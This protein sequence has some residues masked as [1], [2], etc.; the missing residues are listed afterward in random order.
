[1]STGMQTKSQAQKNGEVSGPKGA[2]RRQAAT[3]VA[4]PLSRALGNQ[5]FGRLLSRP[6]GSTGGVIQR[7]CA[8][9]G[10]CSKCSG[11]GE[12][13]VQTKLRVSQ[14]GD[15][16]EQEADHTADTVM[17]MPAGR[18]NPIPAAGPMLVQRAESMTEAEE[19]K[20]GVLIDAEFGIQMKGAGGAG[21]TAGSFS[22]PSSGGAPLA[23]PVRSFFEGR[24]G[25][26][27]SA[28]RVHTGT[29]A[30]Q[31]AQA[32]HARAY[33]H[34]NHIVFR[35]GEYSP[36]SPD[37][38]WLL[39]H[40]LTHVAQQGY[41]PAHSENT[42]AASRM[43]PSAVQRFGD[44]LL[45]LSRSIDQDYAKG[46]TDVELEAAI[47]HL[48]DV[49]SAI[50]PPLAFT[51]ENEAQQAN[52][53]LLTAERERRKP[54]DVPFEESE[55]D[56]EDTDGPAAPVGAIVRGDPANLRA[57]PSETG[58]PIPLPMNTKLIIESEQGTWDK[59]KT[60]D[61]RSGWIKK[62]LV[63]TNLPDPDS[64]L[65]IIQGS[66]TAQKIA[67]HFYG[68]YAK[69][70]GQD[71]RF[72]VNVLYYIN[73]QFPAQPGSRNIYR[74]DDAKEDWDKTVV[75]KGTKIWIPGVDAAIALKGVVPS[76]S[77]TH[78][79]WDT[80][81]DVF[82]G[83]TAFIV[84]LLEGALESIIDV[85]VGLWDLIK[86]AWSVVKSLI[87]GEILSD[88]KKLIDDISKLKLQDI[89]DAGVAWFKSKWFAEGTW[90]RWKFRGWLI[91]YVI[92]EILML[93][94]SDGIATALKWVGKT[95]KLAKVLE[96][97][98]TIVKLA[99][100]AKK[101]TGPAVDGVRAAAK[102]L[103]AIHAW[104]MSVLRIPLEIIK[105]TAEA[106]L[107]PLKGLPEWIKKKFGDLAPAFMKKLLGCASPCKVNVHEIEEWFKKLAPEAVK[108]AKKLE[109]IE[110]I[111]AALP[112]RM[113]T[114]LIKKKLKTRP[115]L[116]RLIKEAKL[117][118]VDL[119]KL[120]AFLGEGENAAS[121]YRTFVKY[122][123]NVVP[124]KT[125]GNLKKLN[126]IAEALVEADARQ[127]AALKGP[128]FENF[129]KINV[130]ELG[131]KEFAKV[132]FK[133]SASLKLTK[134]TRTADNFVESTGAVWDLKHGLSKVPLDQVE[135]Y[136][137][138]IGQLTPNGKE[139][140]T[141][142]YLFA[143]E[144]MAKENAQLAAKAGFNVHYLDPATNAIVKLKL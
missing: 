124:V 35:N 84:G 38:G 36:I 2:V 144:A 85:F 89:V 48:E 3:A 137:K 86:I 100:K 79:A 8:C 142:N 6:A 39:A 32:L 57:A 98:P 77:I 139:V 107:A 101:L 103:S 83:S 13:K 12:E 115:A 70:W 29:A 26:D 60:E 130:P 62:T 34:R 122:L 23:G 78:D 20:Q 61:G 49:L 82:I 72:F 125:E 46:L 127:G 53:D 58:T 30:D 21:K 33:T 132:T 126:T 50:K 91:G 1:M 22:V 28:V 120:E 18:I 88:I 15:R 87:T 51:P 5:A 94:F 74:P 31:S 121:A 14:P 123:T 41:A 55:L 64:T 7:K 54:D 69:D 68:A 24:M 141:I 96:K 4:M 73:Q 133:R 92:M 106:V 11:E 42:P 118:A 109:S 104:A 52:L 138:L 71:E 134:A 140:K 93:I 95:G 40:E 80:I 114:S 111:L 67:Q 25:R 143:T 105:D 37:G 112:K 47:A 45:P 66:D 108:G 65:Y 113:A 19:D 17:R 116:L 99:E 117:T 44:T 27:L 110:E 128:L 43:A 76:G 90:D 56:P 10:T 135:D 131:G 16:F 59:V 9:G 129:A 136:A 119:G 63:E 81:K 102:A 97:F 75:V